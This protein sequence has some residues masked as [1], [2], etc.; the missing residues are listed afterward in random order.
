VAISSEPDIELSNVWK[1][2]SKQQVLNNSMREELVSVIKDS[3]EHLSD[4]D[5][6]SIAVRAQ[7]K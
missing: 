4:F 2:Y 5:E 7:L 6:C 1:K 3:K